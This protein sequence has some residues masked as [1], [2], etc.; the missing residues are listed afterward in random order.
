MMTAREFS[1]MRGLRFATA[2]KQ[3]SDRK[4]MGKQAQLTRLGELLVGKPWSK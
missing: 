4:H 3:V 1:R 2:A